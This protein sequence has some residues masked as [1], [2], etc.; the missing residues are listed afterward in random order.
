[1]EDQRTIRRE[2]VE[3][4]RENREL[5]R[6]VVGNHNLIAGLTENLGREV[7]DRVGAVLHTVCV[8]KT[9]SFLGPPI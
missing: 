7:E 2:L 1:M 9:N 4:T 5:R 6:E 3:M 8:Y